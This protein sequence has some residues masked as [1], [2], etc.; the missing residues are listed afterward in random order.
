MNRTRLAF[1]WYPFRSTGKG[2]EAF[3]IRP[4]QW[5]TTA[6]WLCAQCGEP[7]FPGAGNEELLLKSNEQK[8]SYDWSHDG[9]FLLYGAVDSGQ[10]L[11]L[12]VVPL[13]GP[14]GG[15]PSGPRKLA[16]YLK[17][18]FNE[19][20]ARFSP[21]SRLVAYTSNES[22]RNDVYVQPFPASGGQWMVSRGGGSQ[23]R[24]R[25]DGPITVVLNWR[26]SIPSPSR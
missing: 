7:F 3:F 2:A 8:S 1:L 12:W 21:D 5:F 26:R 22:G 19:H 16:I 9:R 17:T 20:Q 11:D 24:W 23:P 4:S 15:A 25:R 6:S 10:A 14:E 18:Q 13:T